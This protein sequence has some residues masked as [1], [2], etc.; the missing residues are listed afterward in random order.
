MI[1]IDVADIVRA[2]DSHD[3][4]LLVDGEVFPDIVSF[5]DFLLVFNLS[6]FGHCCFHDRNPLSL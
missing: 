6:I 5:A 2:N 4:E 3:L 1:Q